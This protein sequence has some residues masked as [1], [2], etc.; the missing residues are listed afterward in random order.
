M[1]PP[2]A[3]RTGDLLLRLAEALSALDAAPRRHRRPRQVQASSSSIA[4]TS[5]ASERDPRS[6]DA[7]GVGVY[8]MGHVDTPKQSG[9][10]AEAGEVMADGGAGSREGS[11][12][13][14]RGAGEGAGHGEGR[15]TSSMELMEEL[16]LEPPA[17]ATAALVSD[18]VA[19]ARVEGSE[20]AA[21]AVEVAAEMLGQG[22]E[23]GDEEEPAEGDGDGES[24]G[25]GDNGGRDRDGASRVL[26]GGANASVDAR[27]SARVSTAGTDSAVSAPSSKASGGATGVSGRPAVGV[28]D[29]LD[30][31]LEALVRVRGIFTPHVR[32]GRGEDIA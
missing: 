20:M 17:L 31:T 16:A 9:A 5:P 6:E 8:A 21:A 13:E 4:G 30:L 2:P 22:R 15:L 10:A 7:E 25:E 19:A 14:A 18:F 24:G 32:C 23:D 28:E 11:S 3:P 1:A 27:G 26:P 12:R 29:H